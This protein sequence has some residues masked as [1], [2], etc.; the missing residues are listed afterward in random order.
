M[1]ILRSEQIRQADAITIREEPILS[2]DLMERASSKLFTWIKAKFPEVSN[3]K[4][5]VLVG[6][7]N[8]GG[9]GLVLARMLHKQGAKPEVFIDSKSGS[10]DR[11]SN[12]QRWLDADGK[13]SEFEFFLPDKFDL[14]IDALFGTGLS[15]KLEG[16]YA[17]LIEVL[18]QSNSQVISIDIPS[19]MSGGTFQKNW[20]T[21]WANHT[22]SFQVPKLAF[23]DPEA[24]DSLGSWEI[25]DIGLDKT[26]LE[27]V[28]TDD[29]WLTED[30]VKPLLKKRERFSH[31]GNYGHGV[32]AAGSEG[33]MGACLLAS[34][35]ALHSGIGLL[36]LHIPECGRSIAQSAVPEAMI[37]ETSEEE[38]KAIS[39]IPELPEKSTAFGIGPGLGLGGQQ[40]SAVKDTLEKVKLPQVWDADALN[41]LAQNPEWLEHLPPNSIL[42]PHP[43]EFER[44]AGKSENHESTR[45]LIRS[46]CSRYQCIVILKGGFT[47]IALPNGKLWYNTTGNAGMA[48]GGMGDTLTGLLLSLLAQGM[49]PNEAAVAGVFIHARSGD[50]VAQQWGMEGL[51]AGLVA[52]HMGLAIRSIRGN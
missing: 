5:A 44:L 51:T 8:N 29:Y 18:N 28:P 47:T 11:E 26:F 10:T 24:Q 36:S 35:A 34:K 25:L 19:G 12:L 17:S 22:L 1:K 43:G 45:K 39:S 46:F 23:F 4:I 6:P 13:L 52:E 30:D 31:K 15:R 37:L 48:T 20:P 42:S 38:E 7:G 40:T 14:I 2:I 50:L 27:N 9:D 41:I 3:M 49:T 33:M 21:V 16:K 32:L